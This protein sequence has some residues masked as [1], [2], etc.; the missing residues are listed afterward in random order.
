[1]RCSALDEHLFCSRRR[2]EAPTNTTPPT[3]SHPL[4]AMQQYERSRNLSSLFPQAQLTNLSRAVRDVWQCAGVIID[5]LNCQLVLCSKIWAE[6]PGFSTPSQNDKKW[7]RI[8]EG[9]E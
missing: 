6:T 4:T 7:G 2:Q 8:N 9:D 1:M 3:P 5:P